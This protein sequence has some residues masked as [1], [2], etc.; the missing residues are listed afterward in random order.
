MGKGQFGS[1]ES[2]FKM[3]MGL[4]ITALIIAAYFSPLAL[5]NPVGP[6]VVNGAATMVNNGNTMTVTNTPGAILN[7]QQFNIGQGQTTQFNQQSAQSSVLNRVTGPDASQIMGT[8]RSNGQVFLVNPSG[9]LFGAGAVIDVNRLIAST[10]NITNADFLA[11]NL[12]F[13]GNNGTSV[14]N[15]GAITTPVGGSVY[16]IGNNVTNEGVITTPQGEVVLAAGNS[17]SLVN[18]FTP[19]VNVTVSAP[20]GG[21]AV[22]LGQVTAQGGSINIYGALIRQHGIV[23]ADSA[24]VDTQGNIV[25]S[26]TQSV[27]LAQGSST[28]ANGPTGGNITLSSS[29]AGG[30]TTVAGVVSATGNL[31]SPPGGG[32][33]GGEGVGGNIKILGN[34]QTGTVNLSG[35]IDAS[36]SI[37]P[38][39]LAGEG[40]GEGVAGGFIE[41][42]AAYVNIA[43]TA[44]VTTAAAACP[45]PCRRG[46]SGLWLIDPFDFT[47]AAT[48]GNITG[49]TLSSSLG[50]GNVSI[51]S[52]SGTG[53]TAG[54]VNV[55]DAVAWSANKL[56]LNAQN[57]ININATMNGSG[58]ASLALEY[59]QAAVAAGNLSDY[60][61]HAAV[62]L[63]AG[64][65]F[66]TKLGSDGAVKNY[67]VITSLGA[68][69]SVTGTDLQGMNGGLAGNYALGSNIDATATSAWNAGTGFAP[70]GNFTTQFTGNFDGLGHTISN[71]FINRPTTGNVGLIGCSGTAIQNVGL[72][73]GSVSGANN[74]ANG[75]TKFVGGLVGI[76]LGTVSNSYATCSVSGSGQVGG[77]VGYNGGNISNSYATGNVSGSSSDPVNPVLL[78]GLAGSN[79]A[80][81]ISNSYATGNVY[82]TAG[83]GGWVGGL[84]GY[85]NAGTIISNTYATGSVNDGSNPG[86]SYHAAGG[87]VGV[88]HGTISNAYATGSVSGYASVGGLVGNSDGIVSN[89]FWDTQTS[90]QPTVGVGTNTGT[91][92]NVV[93]MSTT[94]FMTQA[95]FIP[96]GVGGTN[97]DFTNTW[98]MSEGNTRPFLRSEYSTTITN[99][100]QLQLMAM[101]LSAS[102]T[103]GA[104]ISMAELTS[105]ASGMWDTTKGFVPVGDGT[106]NFTGIFDGTNHTITALTINRPTTVYVGLFGYTGTGSAIQ[107]VGLVGGNVSGNDAVGGLVGLSFHSSISNSYATGSVSGS[108]SGSEI[109]GLVGYNY[110]GTVS[111]SYATGSVSGTRIVGGLVGYNIGAVSNS[112]ATGSV[113]GTIDIIGGLV[114]DNST[115][116]T[117]S[118]SYA[119]G[120]VS[121]SSSVGGLVGGNTDSTVV[122]SYATGNVSGSSFVGGLVGHSR[123]ISGSSTVVSSYATGSVS[124]SSEVGGLV[125][126]NYLGSTIINSYAMSSVSG[127][128]NYVGGLVGN[129][130][131]SVN[132]SYATGSVSGNYS[133]GGLVGYN[134][135]VVNNSYA[136]GSVSGAGNVGG[137]VGYNNAGTVSNSYATGNV[138]GT[139][140]IGG[141]VGVYNSGTISNSYWDTQ[142]SGLSIGI[143]AGTTIGVT[144]LTTT[145]MKTMSSFAGWSIAN[146]GGAGAVWRIYEGSSYPLLASF[147]LMPLTVTADNV[148]KTYNGSVVTSLTNASYSVAGAASSGHI[149]NIANP[150]NGAANAGSYT[151]GL[152]SD[153]QGYDI[154]YVN[155]A[156]TVNK[157]AL[158]VT[159][160]A[161]SKTY[162]GLAYSGGNGVVY[163]GFVNS[164]TNAV[165]GGALS[166][167]GTS[168]GAIN[169]GSYLITPGGLTSGNYTLDYVNGALTI[170]AATQTCLT[171]PVLCAN[172]PTV[173]NP[174]TTIA[175]ATGNIT[176]SPAPTVTAPVINLS[177]T[178][179]PVANTT[180][181]TNTTGN[182]ID[183][184][185]QAATAAP[186]AVASNDIRQA[187]SEARKADDEAQKAE[188]KVKQTK[189]PQEKAAAR[190]HAEV[191]S[192]EADAKR[193]DA[194]IR[195]AETE[196]RAAEAEVA[197][198]KSPQEKARAETRKAVAEAKRAEGEVDKATAEAKLAEAEAKGASVPGAKAAAEM[199]K[200][201]AEAK[202]VEAEA[203]KAEVE[204]RKAETELKQAEAEAKTG[205]SQESKAVVEAKKAELEAKKADAEIRQTEREA[206]SAKD[207]AA[208]AAAEAKLT[209]AEA[210]KAE[211]EAKKADVEAKQ[212]DADA[213]SS[214][215]PVAKLVAE[216]KKAEADARKAEAEAKKAEAEVKNTNE[217]E[218]KAKAEVKVLEAEARKADAEAKKAEAEVKVA[219]VRAKNSNNAEDRKE[220]ESKKAEAE[221]KKA[222]AQVK[223]AETEVKTAKAPGEKE[224]A[225]IKRSKAEVK[226]VEAE[227]KHAELEAKRDRDEAGAPQSGYFKNVVGKKAEASVA[228][229]EA[230]QA[231]LEMKQART[232]E[233]RT[234]AEKRFEAKRAEADRKETEFKDAKRSSD[235]KIIETFGGMA[236]ASTAKER[237]QEAMVARHEF[238][239]ETLK[240][241]LNILKADPK[242]ADLKPCS[243]GGGDV[244]IR[245]VNAAIANIATNIIPRVQLPLLTPTVSFLPAIQ[246]KVA[247][248]IGNNA[249]QDSSLPSLN[250]A[251]KDADAVSK[252][253]KEKMGYDVRMV[254]NGTRADI[255]RTLNRVSDETGSKDSVVVYYA[256]HG[257][258]MED[259]KVGYWIPSD[260]SAEDP[261]KWISNSDVNKMLANIPAK[262]MILMS[263]SCF[264]GTLAGEQKVTS[265][266]VAGSS[267]QEILGKRSVL[268]MSSGGEEP[269]IDEGKEGHS[270]FAWHL[271]DKLN[272]VEQYKNGAD[273]FDA[274]K[275]G[276]AKDGIPQT[277]QYGASVS[278]GHMAG[279]EYLFEVRKY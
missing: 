174:T 221:V 134:N 204:I 102:Y 67:T 55:N 211:A 51:L 202:K 268:V 70:V 33:A 273:V 194:K 92:T 9:I 258:Q 257:Y 126:N 271:M 270:V 10:L 133:L 259:T 229:A 31:P 77:L 12:K 205:G 49:A 4:K 264:S 50:G 223:K 252:M 226:K 207:P 121:G 151:P 192:G 34:M 145:Q 115:S 224:A 124:G 80:G 20:V 44:R 256:G 217:P 47:I 106:N 138:S 210:K 114:G 262:Q 66:S 156:L 113:N 84:A 245:P 68:A 218:R 213:R 13:D 232:P 198:V 69:G 52:S 187:K 22:N 6:T 274:V 32:G 195:E 243:A 127:T 149:Q 72:V 189:V 112:Y 100:H 141:L 36:A 168:Q 161:A 90:G 39:P 266:S 56:T 27:E 190:Q 143:G 94:G 104:N 236:L 64:N 11:N 200:A 46:K 140:P 87:L 197:S 74:M 247:V 179:A 61:V 261:N 230:K 235:S 171:N 75:M 148:T 182:G 184:A 105:S 248:V 89:S 203:K 19:H 5:A 196:L 135:A 275:A 24:S 181:T 2:E 79:S 154:S 263:D 125:G 3:G 147:F 118:N 209:A 160:N 117:I 42:S 57:N 186:D 23:N 249:Y 277:P 260:A 21:Q 76:N 110:L 158:S 98:W 65:N 86:A 177:T 58:S 176:Y 82:A 162:D 38:S 254:H 228:K 216:T 269:V 185:A 97:W 152:Y 137:L 1:N 234:A 153:Q 239:A 116:S 172:S 78:G 144:G 208:K 265:G 278:A 157:A 29:G 26:A 164:E 155:G 83:S 165:L 191:K 242:A 250:G 41:T 233:A 48:G 146:T 40:R 251:A 93:G 28:T 17:V 130:G 120:G 166:Y 96:A 128:G 109:G 131:G 30:T 220:V 111:N 227:L 193:A 37:T 95:N 8:L 219:E 53:G 122:S 215:S 107:N 7:W 241:A 62:N 222:D 188:E 132:T 183:S 167:G 246:R 139:S 81:T 201:E 170:V 159:A 175:A 59:G 85:T 60:I 136:T 129:N 253:L 150:Y 25:F 54:D 63:P 119:T 123:A 255:V 43:D 173:S 199:K 267:V 214:N 142:A 101:N 276:V 71:L 73:G 14:V 88:H 240:P 238:K 180:K 15:Q 99:A 178:T 237:V 212:A 206:K 163:S 279:G 91:L 169:A 244:C 45:E 16:L 272:K 231:E 108:G 35:T 225:E 103:L 18:S